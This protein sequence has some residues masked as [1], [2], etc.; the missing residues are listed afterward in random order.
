M[1]RKSTESISG[2]T[3]LF[4]ALG[5][6]LAAWACQGQ[7]SLARR[8]A[9]KLP[10]AFKQEAPNGISRFSLVGALSGMRTVAADWVY[11]DMLQ[12][13]GDR[14]NRLD[15]HYQRLHGLVHELLWLDPYFHFGVQYG[16]AILCWN[17]DRPDEAI[18]ILRKAIRA[19]PAYPRYQ[20]YLAAITYTKGSLM[21]ETMSLLER[22]VQEPDR[23]EIVVRIL[24]NLYLKYE[25]W[26]KVRPYW[27]WVES[28]SQDPRTLGQAR[29]ALEQAARHGY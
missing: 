10:F 28:F 25:L 8:A 21:P 19:D 7:A 29:S 2:A 22:L 13:F 24:G 20:Q 5:L 3:A 16:A 18:D 14:R 11:I 9:F 23:S 12:Y 27:T 17:V 26:P 1:T 15:G 6:L 4:L